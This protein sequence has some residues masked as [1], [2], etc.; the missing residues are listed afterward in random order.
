[1]QTG[2]PWMKQD[3]AAAA[4]QE[5]RPDVGPETVAGMEVGMR[6]EVSPGARRGEVMVSYR[7]FRLAFFVSFFSSRFV[8][9]RSF[10][11]SFVRSFARSLAHLVMCSPR[12]EPIR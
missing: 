7:F 5:E 6:C 11:R 12:N 10:V 9:F 4:E 8:S 2:N 1:M 3:P